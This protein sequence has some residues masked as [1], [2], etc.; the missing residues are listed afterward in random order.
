MHNGGGTDGRNQIPASEDILNI[1]DHIWPR[2]Q[3][4]DSAEKDTPH[5]NEP[6]VVGV[7]KRAVSKIA[8]P[9]FL[10]SQGTVSLS[11]EVVLF[12]SPM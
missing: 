9:N 2:Q 5:G 6:S 8:S 7:L 11:F 12:S 10:D 1:G 3:P 4:S